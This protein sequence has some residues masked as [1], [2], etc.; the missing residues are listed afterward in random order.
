MPVMT[1]APDMLDVR[2]VL[3]DAFEVGGHCGADFK[4]SRFGAYNDARL[5]A[6]F[7]DL[8]RIDRDLAQ[9]GSHH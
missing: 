7:K 8:S 3:H 6:E 5:A 4:L 2:P 1:S 9:L